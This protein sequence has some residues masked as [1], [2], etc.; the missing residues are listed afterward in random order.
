MTSDKST[1]LIV[2]LP[3]PEDIDCIID[4]YD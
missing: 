2:P 3:M 4:F 1:L